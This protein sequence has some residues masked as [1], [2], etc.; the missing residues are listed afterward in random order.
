MKNCMKCMN[1]IRR[2]VHLMINFY[3]MNIIYKIVGLSGS[4]Q[5]VDWVQ[6]WRMLSERVKK[7]IKKKRNWKKEN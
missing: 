1:Q 4:E 7:L 6:Q 2:P 5:E 3:L